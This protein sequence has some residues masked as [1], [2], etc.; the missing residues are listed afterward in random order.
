[1]L[2]INVIFYKVCTGELY[3][4]RLCVE[5][6]INNEYSCISRWYKPNIQLGTGLGHLFVPY[7]I[8]DALY[9]RSLTFRQQP[10]KYRI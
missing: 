5:K 8:K 3:N 1:M 7:E 10:E 2:L 4:K 9:E 6:R